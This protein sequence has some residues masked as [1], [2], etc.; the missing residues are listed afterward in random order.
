MLKKRASEYKGSFDLSSIESVMRMAVIS[1]GWAVQPLI[2]VRKFQIY[3][4][5]HQEKP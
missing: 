2:I 3:R 5:H 4:L 1:L